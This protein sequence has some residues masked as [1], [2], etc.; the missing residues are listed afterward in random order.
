MIQPFGKMSQN[1]Y[2]KYHVVEHYPLI[3]SHLQP[4]AFLFLCQS[5]LTVS[6]SLDMYDLGLDTEKKKAGSWDP[7][8]KDPNFAW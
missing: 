3:S 2:C 6:P 1:V 7:D 4:G 5:L 8:F